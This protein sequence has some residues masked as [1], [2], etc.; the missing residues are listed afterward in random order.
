MRNKRTEIRLTKE[1][2]DY[3]NR[4][5]TEYKTSINEIINAIIS[6]KANE[7]LNTNL[8]MLNYTDNFQENHR[9]YIKISD[10]EMDFLKKQGKLH[11]LNSATKEVKFI[12]LNSIYKRKIFDRIDM[13]ELTFAVN[14]VNKLGR[15]IYALCQAIRSSNQ[16]IN[17]NPD[18]FKAML[19]SIDQKIVQVTNFISAYDKIL[20]RRF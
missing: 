9:I 2:Y 16:I 5:K 10:S 4:L 19:N 15:Q 17:L 8:E 12:I 18:S 13:K 14:S 20:Q 3:L 6:D 7:N 1:N 11:G